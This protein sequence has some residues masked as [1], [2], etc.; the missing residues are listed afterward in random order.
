MEERRG[1]RDREI[2]RQDRETERDREEGGGERM[3]R[4][5][6]KGRRKK[7]RRRK[8]FNTLKIMAQITVPGKESV[9]LPF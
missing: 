6:R 9:S 1:E 4:K 5:R 2:E 3:R 7:R 8:D